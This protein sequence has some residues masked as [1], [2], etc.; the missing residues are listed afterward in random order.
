LAFPASGFDGT[1]LSSQ[2]IGVIA[3]SVGIDKHLN[4]TFKLSVCN[5]SEIHFEIPKTA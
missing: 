5:P 1:E 3:V 2:I 4:P